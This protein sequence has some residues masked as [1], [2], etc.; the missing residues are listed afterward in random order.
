VTIH[1]LKN[2]LMKAVKPHYKA[3]FQEHLREVK[4][5][6]H[7]EKLIDKA[8]TLRNH[9]IGH[10]L[11]TFAF[12]SDEKVE[13]TLGELL[14]IKNGIN[15][16]FDALCFNHDYRKFTPEY[17]PQISSPGGYKTDIEELLDSVA[18][19]S[20]LLNEP[21]Q[22]KESWL[23]ERKRLSAYDLDVVNHYRKKFGLPEA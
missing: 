16:L 15:A 22:D 1:K 12:Q 21:E 10:M 9:Y 4:F 5:T 20:A 11:S 13:L 8:H 19:N 6:K 18:R 23:E 14:E 2:K 7:I 3:A 17:D